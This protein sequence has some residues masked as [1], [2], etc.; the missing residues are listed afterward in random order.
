MKSSCVG[1]FMHS[2]GTCY[3]SQ[4]YGNVRELQMFWYGKSDFFKLR[5]SAVHVLDQI[6]YNEHCRLHNVKVCFIFNCSGYLESGSENKWQLFCL[7]KWFTWLVYHRGTFIR[8]SYHILT[9]SLTKFDLIQWSLP[10]CYNNMMLCIL[11]EATVNKPLPG[12]TKTVYVSNLFIDDCL[13]FCHILT[14]Q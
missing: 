14:G 10:S 8:L 1:V 11:T 5:K 4:Q 13:T 6:I 9:Q 2:T 3:H 12:I 7:Q